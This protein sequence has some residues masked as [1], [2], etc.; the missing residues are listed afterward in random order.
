MRLHLLPSLLLAQVFSFTSAWPSPSGSLGKRDAEFVQVRTKLTHDHSGRKGDPN[1]K[2][3]HESTFNP[4]YDGR[5]A[6]KTLP[7]E[8]RHKHLTALLQSYLS[9]MHAIGA[10]TWLMHG[11]LLGWWWNRKI[12][13]WDSDVDVQVSESSIRFLADFYNMTVHRFKLPSINMEEGR[14]YML[15]VNP[16]WSNA[17]VEDRYNM[18]DARWIDTDTGLFIDITAVRK[19][20]TAEAGGKKGHLMC[21]DKHHY[22]E[23]DIFPLRTSE[24]EGVKV[25]IPYAYADLLQEEYGPEALVQK[26]YENHIFNSEKLEWI[27]IGLD[28]L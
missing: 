14:K 16:H 6:E 12:L 1:E 23:E 4:H 2:Y 11:S 25:K 15:E 13:P 26:S 22:R 10:E 20:R 3:F 28:L 21:K 5:F 7:E 18:I 8:D 24:Y 17:T 27:P 9:T 19:D